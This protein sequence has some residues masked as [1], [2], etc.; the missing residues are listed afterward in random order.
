M[1][2][3]RARILAIDDT[4]ANL[5]TLGAALE[6][7]YELQIATSGTAGIALARNNPPDLILLDVMMPDVDGF[8]TFR[9]LAST[10]VLKDIP[11]IFVTAM[12]HLES[13]VTGLQLGAADYITKPIRIPIARQRIRNLLEREQ[14][15]QEVQLQRDQLRKLV[16]AVEQSPAS[17]VVTNLDACLEYVNQRFTDVTGYS[18]D[19]VIGRNQRFL[20]SGRTSSAT[21]RDMWAA[22]RAG[23]VW[24]G[25]F[26][27]RR[28]NG[29][30]Y[31]EESQIAPIRDAN[32]MVTHYVGVKTDITERKRSEEQLR[33]AASVFIHAREGIMITDANGLIIDVNQAFSSI[34]GYSRDDV[35]GQNPRILRSN[36]HDQSFYASLWRDLHANDFWSGEIWNNRKSGDAYPEHLTISVVRDDRGTPCQFVALFSD[37]SERKAL[38]EKALK[39]AFYDSLTDLPNRRLFHDRLAQAI[40][41]SKRSGC[42][43]ALMFLDL[44]NFK[45]LNDLRGHAAGDL[46]LIEVARRLS[47]CVRE[48][49]TVV[50]FGGDEFVVLLSQ[51]DTDSGVS[52]EQARA[53][54]EKVRA[55]LAETYHLSVVQAGQGTMAIEHHCSASIGV[56][57]FDSQNAVQSDILKWADSAMYQAKEA[58]RN[59]IRFYAA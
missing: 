34:T 49:D 8:E 58:G 14:L 46:L 35:L 45:Q 25:E 22:L 36:R 18:T 41:A 26:I 11:V 59:T 42:Y 39:L 28:K 32:G 51:L 53:V 2:S 23:Q 44:D 5:L 9:R 57:V 38:E 19:E 54:A 43:C 47:A 15:R 40:V 29:E 21:Y 3:R 55:S 1:T 30:I 52:T 6:S 17:V 33:L 37:I 10:P 13:E 16:V 24:K 31:W 27:N 56:V 7:E 50:R 20:Q 4:P 12:D 48:V